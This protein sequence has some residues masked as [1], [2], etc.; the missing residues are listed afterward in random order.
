M[1]TNKIKLPGNRVRRRRLP[2]PADPDA[3][4]KRS[5]AEKC[6]LVLEFLKAGPAK[7]GAIAAVL[8]VSHFHTQH[9]L[10]DL[11]TRGKI[12]SIGRHQ[13]TRYA[14]PAWKPSTATES[15]RAFN[16]DVRRD[17][18]AAEFARQAMKKPPPSLGSW[19]TKVDSREAFN[20][21]L[22]DRFPPRTGQVPREERPS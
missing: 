3:P 8:R 10:R 13:H 20:A 17:L 5:F 12:K 2:T 16:N 9:L 6:A 1:S 4:P 18:P 7:S 11:R 22:T 14:L 19:W 15:Q 21:A